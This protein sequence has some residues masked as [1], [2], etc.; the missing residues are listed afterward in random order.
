MAVDSLIIRIFFRMQMYDSMQQNFV[1]MKKTDHSKICI[2]FSHNDID[3][4]D[5]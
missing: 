1:W 5:F 3:E 2:D 4:N